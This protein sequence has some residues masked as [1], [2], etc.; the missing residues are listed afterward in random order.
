MSVLK[1]LIGFLLAL[2]L[3][4]LVI[5][6]LLPR[7]GRVS[8]TLVEY[9]RWPHGAK[10]RLTNGSHKPIRYVA[11]RNGTPAGSPL[12]CVQKTSN[13][14]TSASAT[15][16]ALS[17]V[18]PIT[19]STTEEFFLFDPTAPPKP[20]D[21]IASLLTRD[22][23]PGQSVEFWFRLESGASPKRV[24]TICCIPPSELRRKLQPWLERVERWC[25]IKPT[26]T[27]Q[28]RVWCPNSL[29]LPPLQPPTNGS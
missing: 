7:S 2:A 21:H 16:R 19:R 8:M 25:R 10:L 12:L 11:E 1:V 23:I 27:G 24:G 28:V 26:P 13:G 14:W 18:N 3:A 22:L 9:T 6:L 17:V 20:G 4:A 15:L 5:G 29:Y